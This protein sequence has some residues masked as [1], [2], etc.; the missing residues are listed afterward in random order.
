MMAVIESQSAKGQPIR[1]GLATGN[2]ML[3]LYERLAAMLNERR[4]D[5]SGLHTF[6]L[7]EYVGADGQSVPLDHPLSYRS[8]M[9]QQFFGRIDPRLGLNR[10]QVHFPDPRQPEAFDARLTSWAD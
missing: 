5:L 9:E 3:G 7:D 1:L 8:Y 4:L 2:T 10:S 6:N